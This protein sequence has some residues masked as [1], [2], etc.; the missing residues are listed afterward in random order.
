MYNN[1]ATKFCPVAKINARLNLA[2]RG[3]TI[4][5]NMGKQLGLHWCTLVAVNSLEEHKVQ[6]SPQILCLRLKDQH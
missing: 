5:W 3:Q 6:N 4:F 1:I 2:E